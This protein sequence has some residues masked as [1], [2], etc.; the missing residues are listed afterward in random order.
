M[1]FKRSL[2][3]LLRSATQG[4]RPERIPQRHVRGPA[5]VTIFLRSRQ[6]IELTRFF[7]DSDGPTPEVTVLL[8]KL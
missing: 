8:S 7:R 1:T 2:G 5:A 4:R 3:L 6:V